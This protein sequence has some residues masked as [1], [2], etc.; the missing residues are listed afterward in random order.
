VNSYRSFIDQHMRERT[1][2]RLDVLNLIHGQ[3]D[4]AQEGFAFLLTDG[5]LAVHARL[6]R[7]TLLQQDIQASEQ[8]VPSH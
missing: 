6:E 4:F 3:I 8:T 2:D 1:R 7:T 5:R